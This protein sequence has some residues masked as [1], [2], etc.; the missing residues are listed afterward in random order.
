[1]TSDMRIDPICPDAEDDDCPCEYRPGC[2]CQ[3]AIVIRDK[4]LICENYGYQIPEEWWT[5]D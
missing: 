3:R 1:M 4:I 2:W 5:V